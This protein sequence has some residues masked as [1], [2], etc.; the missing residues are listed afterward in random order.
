M[1]QPPSRRHRNRRVSVFV[2]L[3]PT[4]S[5][6]RGLSLFSFV[7]YKYATP[8]GF[9][10]QHSADVQRRIFP[11]GHR[12]FFCGA[13]PRTVHGCCVGTDGGLSPCVER[14]DRLGADVWLRAVPRALRA[15]TPQRSVP[16]KTG[17]QPK[18]LGYFRI[19][20][21][22]VKACTEQNH[23]N[24]KFLGF[25]RL[26]APPADGWMRRILSHV[27]FPAPATFAFLA[28]GPFHR[29]NL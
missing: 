22:P 12:G 4:M 21:F 18:W 20:P 9:R 3:L 29:A 24:R 27:H 26:H 5:P 8:T 13:Y 2:R 28:A 25:D 23:G 19:V 14:A 1:A 17:S 10:C 16:T 15:V 7:F 6:L 11:S